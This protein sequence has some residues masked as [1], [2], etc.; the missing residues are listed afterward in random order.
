M[1]GVNSVHLDDSRSTLVN[2]G[3]DNLFRT[4]DRFKCRRLYSPLSR[5]KTRRMFD[6]P[7]LLTSVSSTLGIEIYTCIWTLSSDTSP[8]C[9]AAR[10]THQVTLANPP[11]T[12]FM[13]I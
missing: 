13:Y 1:G 7:L 8:S 10:Y 5:P 12:L 3:G 2:G 6:G 11:W 9:C 4:H